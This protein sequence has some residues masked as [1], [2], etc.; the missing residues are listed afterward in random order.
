MTTLSDPR[1]Q[2]AH[3]WLC[4][5]TDALLAQGWQLQP[6]SLRPASSDA[7]FRRY[8]R[9]DAIHQG[10]PDGL[11]LMDAPPEKEDIRPFMA[12]AQLL[13]R[14]G[15]H[16]PEQ[17]AHDLEQGFLLC[18][19]L[20]STTYAHACADQQ[21]DPQACDA[22]YQ[23]A[24]RALV[25][26]QQFSSPDHGGHPLPLYD[27]GRLMQEMRLFDEW[28]LGRHRPTELTASERAELMG[29]YERIAQACLTQPQVIVHRDFHSRNLMVTAQQNPGVLDFQDAVVGP[30]TYDLV[31]LL[32]DAYIAWPEEVQLDWA[33]RYWQDAKR[34]GLPV[35]QDFSDFWRDVE[36]MGLQRHLKVLGIF[37]RLFYRDGKENYL[38][39]IPVVWQYAHGVARRYQGLGPLA[40]LL[41]RSA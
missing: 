11:I 3:A 6:D 33:V 18:S 41:E 5:Q 28:Y 29:I 25:K 13:A 8:F 39:D 27:H 16:V 7:S 9:L 20:G 12:V 19:D 15:L 26:L 17:F 10:Q 31:S 24:W 1:L 37:A 14:A 22:L 21:H 38:H 36:W 35:P 32:R 23:D 34:A 4:A 40:R 2:R 30:I